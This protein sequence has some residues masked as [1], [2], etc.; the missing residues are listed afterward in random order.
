MLN[1]KTCRTMTTACEV[2]EMAVPPELYGPYLPISNE[3]VEIFNDILSDEIDS[4]FTSSIG[5]CDRCYKD[6]RGH[7][8][9]VAFRNHEFQSLAMEADYLVDNSR[10]LQLYSPA[11]IS[12]L[13]R[14]VSCPRCLESS[15]RRVWIYE[16][17]FSNAPRIEKAIDELLR[18]GINT[19]FLM[20][21]H[22]FAGDVLNEIRQQA[23]RVGSDVI[24]YAV[25]RA[26]TVVSV[27][28]LGQQPDK[29]ETYGTPPAPLVGEG[30]FN[31]AGNPMLYVASTEITA[32]AE[33]GSPGEDAFVAMLHVKGSLRVLDLVD[34]VEE[35]PGF[36]LLDALANSALL[37]APRTGEGWLKRQYVFSRFVADCAR[38]AGF[39]AI[40]YGS[41]Q[42][43][44]GFNYVL[45]TPPDDI[46]SSITLL[47]H[48]R[49]QCPS[50]F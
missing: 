13:K 3:E 28:K 30:R 2:G 27:E 32:A 19:P 34:I 37:A 49:V 18:L 4:D 47:S 41:N 16:H 24:D 29:L 20:L 50:P 43:V 39:D 26:R 6:F 8:P 22:A 23:S 21:E 46:T 38:S 42:D 17:R 7:W 12:T 48:S 5:C 35:Q 15:I 31:H 1:E 11:E 40:R 25:F 10:V 9:N 45:L 36:E 44:S 33:L 14:L